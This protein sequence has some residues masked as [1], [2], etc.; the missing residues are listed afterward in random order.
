MDEAIVLAANAKPPE[1]ERRMKYV[2]RCVD[3]FMDWIDTEGKAKGLQAGPRA[4]V[5]WDQTQN[6]GKLLDYDQDRNYMRGLI[7]QASLYLTTYTRIQIGTPGNQ[8]TAPCLV[9]TSKGYVRVADM[10]R[11]DFQ[12]VL[13]R[14]NNVGK[15]ML[16][17]A[18]VM[19]PNW[20]VIKRALG[21]LEGEMKATLR[22]IRKARKKK[23]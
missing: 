12:P 17:R 23:D 3:E 18:T 22:E 10:T 13:N 5:E 14:F 16:L 7:A 2:K 9:M 20:A 1:S 4:F 19:G 21:E 6:G 15:M 11:E 8:L